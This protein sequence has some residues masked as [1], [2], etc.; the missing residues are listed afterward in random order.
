MRRLVAPL[1]LGLVLAGCT[2]GPNYQRPTV[3]AP[4]GWRGGQAA[5]DPGSLADLAW[6]KLF[7]DDELR[8][9]VPTATEAN[10]D[11]R[12]AVTRVDQAR[13]Q[14]GVTRSAQFPV[15]NAAADL[16]TNRISE[17]V[18]PRGAGGETDRLST[19]VDLA[20]EIDIWGRLRRATEA[21]R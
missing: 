21:A 5:P 18:P 14:L 7:Q 1:A 16:T 4:E 8:R 17:N 13:A 6:W 10:K 9:L 19:T 11:L 2:L 15:I 20:F 3:P 12:I